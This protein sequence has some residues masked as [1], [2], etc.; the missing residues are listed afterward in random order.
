MTE[1]ISRAAEK[2]A[3]ASVGSD[4]HVAGVRDSDKPG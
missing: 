4:F 2:V 3:V 1:S